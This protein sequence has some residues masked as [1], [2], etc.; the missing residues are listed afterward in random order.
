MELIRIEFHMNAFQYSMVHDDIIT[1]VYSLSDRMGEYLN[2]IFMKT[3][4]S[5]LILITNY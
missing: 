1:R 5:V 2:K 3:W 4:S